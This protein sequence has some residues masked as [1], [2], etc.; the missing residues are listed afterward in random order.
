MR[1]EVMKTSGT[2]L[3]QIQMGR[4]GARAG[5]HLLASP[6]QL[7]QLLGG[8]G[9]MIRIA[10]FRPILTRGEAADDQVEFDGAKVAE[11]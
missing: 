6:G 8:G 1:N 7:V 10:I 11:V 3:L 9:Q 4:D 5:D 2:R